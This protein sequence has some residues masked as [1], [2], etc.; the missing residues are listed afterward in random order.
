MEED[1]HFRIRPFGK[2]SLPKR[3][4]FGLTGRQDASYERRGQETAAR[5]GQKDGANAMM[6]NRWAAPKGRYPFTSWKKGP[7]VSVSVG[8]TPPAR[9]VGQPRARWKLSQKS[10]KTRGCSGDLRHR[11]YLPLSP[12]RVESA[13]RPTMDWCEKSWCRANGAVTGRGPPI[14]KTGLQSRDGPWLW[15]GGRSRRIPG[16]VPTPTLEHKRKADSG[17]LVKLPGKWFRG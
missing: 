4:I 8:N 16:P 3:S 10:S 5:P 2:G 7:K 13:G 9:G 6:I 12:N 14:G 15:T 1:R 17:Q 11:R